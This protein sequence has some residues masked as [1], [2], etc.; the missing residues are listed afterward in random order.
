MCVLDV[1][2]PSTKS[3]SSALTREF[4]Q[5]RNPTIVGTVGKLPLLR[6]NSKS[7]KE[8]TQERNLCV[9]RMWEGF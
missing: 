4:T 6:P 7:M 3:Q 1:G 5:G 9:H 2:M 8:F